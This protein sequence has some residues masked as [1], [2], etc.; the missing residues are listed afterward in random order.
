M[1]GLILFFGVLAVLVLGKPVFVPLLVAAFLW[2]LTN[3]ITAYYRKL[4]PYGTKYCTLNQSICRVFDVVAFVM[5]LAT[6]L[7]LLYAFATQI[8]P[9]FSELSARLPEIQSRLM[10]LSH[11]FSDAV[12]IRIDPSVLPDFAQVAAN[13]GMSLGN[14][15][16]SFGMILIYLLFMFIEQSSF[17]KK[18]TALFPEKRRLKKMNFILD[19]IGTNMKKY[20]FMKTAISVATA[21]LSYFWLKYLGLEFSGIWAF[22]IFI[23][24]YIPTFGAIV[25]TVLPLLYALI[26]ADTLQL[27][28]LVAGGLIAIQIVLS[29]IIEPKLT[30]KTLNLSTLA[31]LINLVVWGMLWGAIGMFFSV[32]LL[33]ATFVTTAQFDRTR[34]IAILLSANG[35]IPAKEED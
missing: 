25:A 28:L 18:I 9:M 10:T 26:T 32:P 5:S 2:Y 6:L 19:S 16:M 27:P 14:A 11:Y 4:L 12:G 20:M 21:V 33:V 31:I 23:T 17:R 1:N 8:R 13:V 15:A 30:G 7:G 22:I 29:N 35:E 34:W 24:N 3:A